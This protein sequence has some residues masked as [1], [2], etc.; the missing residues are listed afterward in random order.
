MSLLTQAYILDKFGPRLSTDQICEV[1]QITKP[2]FYN[3]ISAGTCAM[4][5]YLE[6]GKR[7]ADYRNAA[8]FFD[9]ARQQAA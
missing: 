2:A 7:W 6:G 1:M 8:E 4:K 9:V 3:Q 5:T